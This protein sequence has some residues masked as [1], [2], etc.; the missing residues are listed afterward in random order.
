[1]TIE[2]RDLDYIRWQNRAF[3]FYVAARACF[4][5]GIY[6]P[7]VFLSQ[8]C[9]EQLLKATLIWCDPL[10]KPKK[11]GGHKLSKMAEMIQ[12][13]IPNQGEFTV[14]EYLSDG[15][16]QSLSRYP[17][18]RG[19]GFGIPGTLV[20]DVDRLFVDLVEM[21]PFQF[22]SELFR[23]LAKRE[24]GYENYYVELE[25]D[26]SEMERL[27]AHVVDRGNQH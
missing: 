4:H 1:M 7:A 10:F 8:Q 21:V 23:T 9:V 15:K 24:E 27:R 18:P 16:Y 12:E 13:K 22:D 5:K 2:E 11:H 26:N 17:A 20:P 25:R 19:K 3:W 14:P 6:A